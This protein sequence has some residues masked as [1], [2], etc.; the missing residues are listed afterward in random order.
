MSD[1]DS[2][3]GIGDDGAV[4]HL[5]A[6]I[7]L[8]DITLLSHRGEGVNLAKRRGA[9]A[10]YVYP[11]TGR[12]GVS[13]P[14]G[15]DDI[16]GA[17]G[18]TPETEGFRDHYLRFR[19]QKI[20]VFGVST[21]SDEHQQELAARLAVPFQLLSDEMFAF[22]RALALPTFQAGNELYLR[23]LTLFIRDGIIA[24][25]FYPVERP[26]E[27]AREILDWLDE[28]RRVLDAG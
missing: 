16:P 17:H 21:Q 15:W 18:S 4:R 25:T 23:R 28:K 7:E 24:H 10:V 5:V 12:P 8:P 26:G 19:S 2:G 1:A 9:A 14:P 3:T 6:G 13:D 11:W 22:Q 20:E 27:H